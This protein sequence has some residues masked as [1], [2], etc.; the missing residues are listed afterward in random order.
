[1]GDRRRQGG[2]PRK[3]ER[4]GIRISVTSHLNS[5]DRINLKLMPLYICK[6]KKMYKLKVKRLLKMKA[7]YYFLSIYTH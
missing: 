7:E 3:Q 4:N 6:K 1:M 5:L 2:I